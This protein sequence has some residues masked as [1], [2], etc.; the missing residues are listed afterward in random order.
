MVKFWVISSEACSYFLFQWQRIINNLVFEW[1][2]H[3]NRWVMLS[4]GPLRVTVYFLLSF[5]FWSRAL[6][7]KRK[8]I[9]KYDLHFWPN[10]RL[11]WIKKSKPW[12]LHFA[13][14]SVPCLKS[15]SVFN[16]PDNLPGFGP[17]FQ[18]RN[19]GSERLCSL[20]EV[21]Q[22]VNVRARR[23]AQISLTSTPGFVLHQGIS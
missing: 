15:T 12:H 19:L 8:A 14:H 20:P 5:S 13:R 22:P 18:M 1:K 3:F 9:F 16:L 23:W 4:E 7:G 2:E 11:V 17:G 21:T 10:Q 6:E